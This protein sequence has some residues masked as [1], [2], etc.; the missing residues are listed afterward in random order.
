[1]WRLGKRRGIRKQPVG[2]EQN[3]LSLSGRRTCV[4][5]DQLCQWVKCRC[6]SSRTESERWSE[7]AKIECVLGLEE[8]GHIRMVGFIKEGFLFQ[9]GSIIHM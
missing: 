8:N 4:R 2:L 6:L 5:K 3:E 1:M 9:M 7:F